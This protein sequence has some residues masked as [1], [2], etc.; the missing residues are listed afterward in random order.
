MERKEW[1]IVIWV[2]VIVAIILLATYFLAKAPTDAVS[3]KVS[4]LKKKISDDLIR[5]KLAREKQAQLEKKAQTMF[6]MIACLVI[7]VFLGVNGFLIYFGIPWISAL[8][9]TMLVVTLLT[10]ISSFIVFNR[11]SVNALLDLV[12]KQ[13]MLWIYKRNGFSAEVIKMIE[14][15]IAS[16]QTKFSQTGNG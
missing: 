15:R 8:E 7:V 14:L 9:G 13:V 1:K 6:R 2:I 5:L 11:L 16:K 12:Q 4:S 3:S 10:S